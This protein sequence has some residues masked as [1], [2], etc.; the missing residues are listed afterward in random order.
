MALQIASLNSGS[1]GNCYYIGN[2]NEAILIDAGLSLRETEKRMKQLSLSLKKVKGIF[3]THEHSDHIKGLANIAH[4]YQIPIYITET[5]SKAA[6]RLIKHLAVN[7]TA[8]NVVEIGGLK[9]TGFKK[10]H[11]ALDPHSF[12]V[13][14]NNIT[15]GIFTDIGQVCSNLIHY[16][17]QCHAAFLESNYDDEMLENG[18]YSF[19]LKER[20]R[21]GHGHLSNKQAAQLF[22]Q[23]KPVFMS[24]LF[25]SHLS[26]ENNTHELALNAFK[27]FAQQTKIFI[28]SR[29]EATGVH[30][31]GS[32]IVKQQTLLFNSKAAQL[33]LFS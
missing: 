6:I 29:Y 8:P 20:I 26:K 33:K 23:H 31:I 18:R 16:F 30:E 13:Q 1:N 22:A 25:L 4:K 17:K 32:D 12:I 9:I 11:D 21:N 10:H 2:N 7:Y 3:V 28:A 24:H 19:V 27:P 5:T 15:V 14:Q